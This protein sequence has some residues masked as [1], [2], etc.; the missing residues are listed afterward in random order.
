MDKVENTAVS[1]QQILKKGNGFFEH[2]I[3]QSILSD[4]RDTLHTVQTKPLQNKM[5]SKA[6][7][8]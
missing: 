2:S 8:A 3:F 1:F 6:I 7:R 5:S 4:M